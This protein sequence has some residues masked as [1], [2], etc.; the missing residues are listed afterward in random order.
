LIADCCVGTIGLAEISYCSVSSVLLDIVGVGHLGCQIVGMIDI[1]FD[2]VV[3]GMYFGIVGMG[4]C[5]DRWY[6]SVDVVGME[7]GLDMFAL[8]V[9]LCS[10]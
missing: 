7:P 5:L 1:G 3:A 4:N 8:A 6:N 10:S 2:I 9:L